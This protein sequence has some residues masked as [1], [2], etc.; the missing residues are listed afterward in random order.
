MTRCISDL[1][2]QWSTARVVNLLN[3]V[4]PC[5]L[6]FIPKYDTSPQSQSLKNLPKNVKRK[7]VISH[8][9]QQNCTLKNL[10][11]YSYS[12]QLYMLNFP[13]I[14]PCSSPPAKTTHIANETVPVSPAKC[15]QR[16]AGSS[17]NPSPNPSHGPAGRSAPW[18]GGG[19]TKTGKL[20]QLTGR[21]RERESG[22]VNQL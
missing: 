18:G 3:A 16:L 7:L 1:S 8:I 14:S 21:E 2:F 4:F 9:S 11:L 12:I 13:E 20:T 5:Q 10:H 6:N 15:Q 17:A 19:Q 22:C